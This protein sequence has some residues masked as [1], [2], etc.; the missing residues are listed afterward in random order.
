MKVQNP[1]MVAITITPEASLGA[2]KASLGLTFY[3]SQNAP[4]K[5][6]HG[7]FIGQHRWWNPSVS[8]GCKVVF[9]PF[10]NGKPR[11]QE[12][13]LTGFVADMEKKQL[14]GRPVGVA[15]ANDGSLLV[16]DDI[17]D[18]IWRISTLPK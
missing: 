4:R 18:K 6:N 11:K 2:H 16:A 14:Y 8:S 13:F 15:V 7:T 1:D 12:N 9:V 3:T 10:K 5:Y 17:S